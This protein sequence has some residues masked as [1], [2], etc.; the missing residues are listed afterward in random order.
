MTHCNQRAMGAPGEGWVGVTSRLRVSLEFRYIFRES[1]SERVEVPIVLQVPPHVA[2]R[3]WDVLEIA[4][5]VL[6]PADINEP[7][8]R[9][10]V[11][12][13]AGQVEES[14]ERHPVDRRSR[15][16]PSLQVADDQFVDQVL[17]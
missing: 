6:L 10:E 13:D 9:L 4:I 15:L 1:L 17:V 11:A 8:S 5:V 16:G 14:Q 3:P 7:P 12:L 2:Q